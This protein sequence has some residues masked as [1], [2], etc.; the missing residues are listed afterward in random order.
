MSAEL[1]DTAR[2]W[3]EHDPD[4]ITRGEILALA[5]SAEGGDEEALAELTSRFS[6]PLTFG[7]AGLRAAVGAGES[8]MNVAVVTRATAGVGA[9]LADTIQQFT[10]CESRRRC[11]RCSKRIDIGSQIQE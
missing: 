6:G 7:T 11:G 5:T 8:R 10:I 1:L 4:P 2:V 9:Y 3:A